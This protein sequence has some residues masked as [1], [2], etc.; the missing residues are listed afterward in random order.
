MKRRFRLVAATAILAGCG[1]PVF[2]AANAVLLATREQALVAG[3]LED[4]KL[5]AVQQNPVVPG[6]PQ[7]FKVTEKT[8]EYLKDKTVTVDSDGS[9]K[10]K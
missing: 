8:L 6:S 3:V 9:V 7:K 2:A 1:I 4:M 10:I 5:E